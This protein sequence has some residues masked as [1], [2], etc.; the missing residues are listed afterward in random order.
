MFKKEKN[1]PFQLDIKDYVKDIKILVSDMETFHLSY[2]G[3]RCGKQ[4]V[5]HKS[6]QPSRD[7]YD[8]ITIQYMWMHENKVHN[9][10]WVGQE[11]SSRKMIEEF[12]KILGEADIVIGKNSDSFDSK[13]LN[14]LRMVHGLPPLE[15]W[16]IASSRDDLQKQMKRFF[17]LPSYS[18]D[19]MCK[20]LFKSGKDSMCFADWQE[21][22][23]YKEAYNFLQEGMDKKSLDILCKYLYN[24]T[25]KQVFELGKKAHKKMIKYG[26][27]DVLDTKAAWLK[28]LPY[29][30]PRLNKSRF[31]GHKTG[32]YIT[33]R[34]CAGS[35]LSKRGID[36]RNSTP[37]QEW[38]CKDCNMYAG[39]TTILKNNKLGKME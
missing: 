27:K 7:Q 22:R 12:D 35:N 25:M 20:M 16:L 38:H 31:L 8:I 18:L 36:R 37:K 21:I 29:I 1:T 34:H 30:K 2:D 19:Y 3:W 39:R 26:N 10:N 13:H 23:N 15:N 17:Y 28:L 4:F 9:L 32:E 14:T 11:T 33:C 6:L 24:G 5:N